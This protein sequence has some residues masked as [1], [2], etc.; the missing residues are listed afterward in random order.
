MATSVSDQK[1][2][3]QLASGPTAWPRATVRRRPVGVQLVGLGVH[4][5]LRHGVGGSGRAAAR[6]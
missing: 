4:V 5:G 2:L 3:L 6:A 1:I